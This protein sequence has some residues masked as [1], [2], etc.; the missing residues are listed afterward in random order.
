MYNIRIEWIIF[1]TIL[2]DK[3]TPRP[4]S[5]HIFGVKTQVEAVEG[6]NVKSR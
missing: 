4:R 6:A 5:P 1:R 3:H 2:I